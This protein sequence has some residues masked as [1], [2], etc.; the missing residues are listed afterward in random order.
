M[1]CLDKSQKLTLRTALALSFFSSFG[2]PIILPLFPRIMAHFQITPVET[3]LLI[4]MYALPGAVIIPILG[5]LQ[6]RIGR[7]PIIVCSLLI[8]ILGCIGLST[9][10]SFNMMLLWRMVQGVSVTPIEAMC[11]TLISDNFSKEDRLRYIGY[12]TSALFIGVASVPL[13][14]TGIMLTLGWRAALLSPALPGIILAFSAL[15]LPVCYS[16]S[17]FVF[18]SYRK[19]LRTVLLSRKM[20]LLFALRGG[21][22]L[23]MFGALH[24]YMPFLITEKL[25]GSQNLPG[26]CMALFSIFLAF[27]SLMLSRLTRRFGPV[28]TGVG[29]GVLNTLGML[30][31]AFVPQLALVFI[32]LTLFGAGAGIMQSLNTAQVAQCVRANAKATVMSLYATL[33]RS[34]QALAPLVFSMFYVAGGFTLL[35]GAAAVIA[36]GLTLLCRYTFGLACPADDS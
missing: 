11:N 4:A 17:E 15:R 3:T 25:G 6:D 16:P 36:L 35:Y 8:S 26:I 31:L 21:S 12:S 18:S 7:K 29:A 23:I 14:S 19:N 28:C 2:N 1:S 10:E 9:A 34:A 32:P 33:F 22:A 20:F 27:G 30:G 5:F 24:S 13:I